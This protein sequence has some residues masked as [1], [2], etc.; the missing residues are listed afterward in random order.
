[1]WTDE[2][3]DR[4]YPEKRGSVGKPI[5]GVDVR[6]V[7]PGSGEEMPTGASG[8]LH[9]RVDRVG[10]HWIETTDFAHIDADGF[11]YVTGRADNAIDRGGYSVPPDMVADV[12]RRHPAVGDAAVVGLPDARLGEVPVAAVELA[13]GATSPDEAELIDFARL[14]LLSYQVPARIICVNELPRN[15]SLKVMAPAVRELFGEVN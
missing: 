8:L 13:V 14:Y 1:V 5:P 3:Y 2:L 9:A 11:V 12:L 10:T 4:Y 15:A 7:D 6:I